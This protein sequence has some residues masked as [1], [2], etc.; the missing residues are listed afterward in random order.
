MM[1]EFKSHN[2]GIVNIIHSLK[3][4]GILYTGSSDLYIRIHSNI[5]DKEDAY[6]EMN[7]INN[8]IDLIQEKKI[9]KKFLYNETDNMLIMALSSGYISYY[10]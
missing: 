9:L 5:D 1:K 6:K 2:A 8:S 4:N 10:D 3:N 7:I